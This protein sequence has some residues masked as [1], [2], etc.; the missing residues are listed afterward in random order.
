MSEKIIKENML[1]A[2]KLPDY[3]FREKKISLNAYFLQKR[4]EISKFKLVLFQK[5]SKRALFSF[6]PLSTAVKVLALNF[7]AYYGLKML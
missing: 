5:R 6:L 2:I 1:Y 4:E 7:K 3:G